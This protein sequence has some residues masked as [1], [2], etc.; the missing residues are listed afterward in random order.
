MF[1]GLTVT[2]SCSGMANSTSTQPAD[3]GRSGAG[4]ATVRILGS[5]VHLVDRG[6]VLSRMCDWIRA[7]EYPPRQVVVAGFHGIWLARQEPRLNAIFRAADLWVP[8]GVA[9]VWVARCRG[10]RR[11]RRLAGA[12]LMAGF[13]ELAQQ[14]GFRSYFFGSSPE[15]LADLADRTKVL[16]PRHKLAGAYSPPFRPVS[17][18]ED[19]RIVGH[20]NRARP[21]VLWVSLGLPKQEYWIAEHRHR[22]QVPVIIGVGAAFDFL[23][24]RVKRCP[25]WLGTCGLEWA[26][27]LAI[28]PRRLWRRSLV[29][30]PRFLWHVALEFL[31]LKN[32]D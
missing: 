16:Y 19:E 5:Q 15:N 6:Y 21:D 9:P 26:F 13:L 30:G 1:G 23:S 32:Y 12:D 8:D 10:H 4:L 29:D 28:E 14:E 7:R 18:E 20:I 11:V 24:G 27:R 3:G 2:G 22:L 17:P 31:E 25:E